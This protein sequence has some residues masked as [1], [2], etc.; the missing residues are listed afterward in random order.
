M[1]NQRQLTK[2]FRTSVI[3]FGLFCIVSAVTI[4]PDIATEALLQDKSMRIGTC[5]YRM[6]WR[7]DD[8][9]TI[10]RGDMSETYFSE[11]WDEA[12][13][14]PKMNIWNPVF[15]EE[16]APYSHIRFVSWNNA[17]RSHTE[18]WEERRLP[19]DPAQRDGF[20]FA[21]EWQIDLVNR[22][23]KDPW[24]CVPP[25]ADDHYMTELAKLIKVRLNKNLYI[26][27][28]YS[29]E[30]WGL[31]DPH[32]YCIK[33]GKRLKTP[34]NT[35]RTIAEAFSTYRSLQMF[36]IFEQV[37]GTEKNRLIKVVCTQAEW[38]TPF[39]QS[40]GAIINSSHWNPDKQKPD[41]LCVAPYVGGGVDGGS[42]T[43]GDDFRKE[44][45]KNVDFIRQ[46][47]LLADKYGLRFGTYEGGQGAYPNDYEHWGA[48]QY[49]G[50][51]LETAHK[52][53]ALLDWAQEHTH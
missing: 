38:L 26:Y 48:K 39:D 19:G 23:N 12:A 35:D 45:I 16:L 28:E 18:K 13:N 32:Q 11:A 1:S 42:V 46:G 53:R 15:I 33:E 4:Q 36:T 10:K 50:E 41:M 51:S 40:Y 30:T 21:Y 17:T 6:A 22:T 31:P 9:F 8:A 5:L 34:G 47:K 2:I 24:I 7:G 20:E 29:N 52:Y 14:Q 49:T 37:F 27:L 3:L 25:R 43:V 44:L